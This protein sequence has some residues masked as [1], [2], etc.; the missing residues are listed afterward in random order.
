[1]HCVQFDHGIDIK[2]E[3]SHNRTNDREHQGDI[4]PLI[5]TVIVVFVALQKKIIENSNAFQPNEQKRF[6]QQQQNS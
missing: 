3:Q 4:Y 1:M 2:Y 5:D 6:Q